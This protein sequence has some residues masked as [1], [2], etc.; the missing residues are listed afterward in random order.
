[1]ENLTVIKIPKQDSHI[2]MII[3]NRNGYLKEEKA[4]EKDSD[5]SDDDGKD[6]VIKQDMS[7]GTYGYEGDTH[8]Y[9]D[10]TD[11][12][13]Y[14]WDREKNAWFPKVDEDFFGTL[15]NELWIY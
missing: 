3:H 6:N 4:A 5:D 9:T 12:T 1:M 2:N 10:A 15:S 7:K 11:G 8:T 13:V 14:I